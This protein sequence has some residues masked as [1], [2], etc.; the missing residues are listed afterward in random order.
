MPVANG[1]AGA[2][3]PYVAVKE[4]GAMRE[5]GNRALGRAER[6]PFPSQVIRKEEG[7]CPTIP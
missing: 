7:P 3:S 4:L 5:R 1:C 6:S 2:R